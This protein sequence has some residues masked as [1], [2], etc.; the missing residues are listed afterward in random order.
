[1]SVYHCDHCDQV[2]DADIHGI[3]RHPHNPDLSICDMCY[4][5]ILWELGVI[6]AQF[7]QKSPSV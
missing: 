7:V 1:M 3:E 2:K 4:G 6:P 5:N